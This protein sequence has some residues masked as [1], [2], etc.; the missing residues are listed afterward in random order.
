[1][2][3]D[4]D[5]YGWTELIGMIDTSYTYFNGIRFTSYIYERESQ[6]NDKPFVGWDD[7]HTAVGVEL[8]LV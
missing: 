7:L 8:V 1:M 5:G 4:Y 6:F 2:Y 3:Y